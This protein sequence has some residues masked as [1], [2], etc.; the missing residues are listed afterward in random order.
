MADAPA[1][2]APGGEDPSMEEILQSIRRIIAE[3]GDEGATK[4]A[5]NVTGDIQGSDV[6]ELTEMVKDDGSVVSLKG[7]AA[8]NGAAPAAPVMEIPAPLAAQPAT[9]PAA[10]TGDVLS[11]IENALSTPAAPAATQA[12]LPPVPVT[13]P[14]AA[15]PQA[16]ADTLLSA[17]ASSAAV[18]SV[19]KLQAA[20][21]PPIPPLATTPSP[22]FQSGNTVEAMVA[23]MLKPMVKAWLDANLPAMVERIVTLEIRRLTK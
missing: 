9:P 11:Q 13:P 22:V 18:A 19:K 4:D 21:E 1:T 14:P 8:P 6:L 17:Q 3:E 15:K 23:A 12:A 16:A 5:G 10:A 20:A 2:Q 7:D